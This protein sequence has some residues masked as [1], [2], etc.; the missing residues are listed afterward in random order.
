MSHFANSQPQVNKHL[1]TQV[2]LPCDSMLKSLSNTGHC[3]G[4]AA[5]CMHT[6]DHREHRHVCVCC[7]SAETDGWQH[8]KA[9]NV[10][11]VCLHCVCV[12]VCTVPSW[13]G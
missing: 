13:A 4:R 1:P 12:C 7:V 9:V 3:K 8:Q 5:H 10:L 2:H 6:A 11:T